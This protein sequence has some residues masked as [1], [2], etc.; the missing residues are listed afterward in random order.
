MTVTALEVVG[1]NGTGVF[2]Q[3]G[4]TNHTVSWTSVLVAIQERILSSNS[5]PGDFNGT[6]TID[7]D[8]IIGNSG[9]GTFNQGQGYTHTVGTTLAASNAATYLALGYEVGGSGSYILTAGILL[10]MVSRKSVFVAREP[11]SQSA[12]GTHTVQSATTNAVSPDLYLGESLNSTG[13]YNLSGI[14]NLIVNGTE[15]VGYSGVGNFTQSGSTNTVGTPTT[16]TSLNIGI[17]S[18]AT[19]TY[20]LSGTGSIVV[21]G[22]EFIG[23]IGSGAF[24]QTG[25]INMTSGLLVGGGFGVVFNHNLA[26]GTGIY[27]LQRVGRSR[28]YG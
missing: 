27:S 15:Y 22:G 16:A 9:S 1:G 14:G 4:G 6:L 13:I 23:D 21:S 7:L 11:S 5:S 28:R 26:S 8:E 2:D 18:G 17:N 19:G 3:S 25:G 20:S 12:A 10:L 24:I